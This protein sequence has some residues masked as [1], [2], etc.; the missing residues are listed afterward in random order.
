MLES[1]KK[2]EL[3]RSMKRP[4]VSVIVPAYNSEKTIETAIED[5]RNQTYQNL[6]IIVVDDGSSDHTF[7]ICEAK[8]KLDRRIKIISK[9]NG[10]VASARN[11][12][13]QASTG[14][15]IGFMDADDRVD[16]QMYELLIKAAEGNECDCV[17][18]RFITEYSD[19]FSLTFTHNNDYKTSSVEGNNACLMAISNKP[20]AISVFLWN[21]IF[22][23][24]SI[25]NLQFDTN[26]KFMEDAVFVYKA[27]EIAKRLK[28]IDVPCYHYRYSLSSLSRS[29]KTKDYLRDVEAVD[30][31][32]H[33]YETKNMKTVATELKR[34]NLFHCARS[35]ESIHLFRSDVDRELC[36]CARYYIQ[37][38]YTEVKSLPLM[39]K[40]YVIV[41]MR[42]FP[43]YKMGCV[44]K[45]KCKRMYLA[46]QG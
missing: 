18:C 7:E 36:D 16:P 43:I 13:K 42:S 25:E 45:R 6:E 26:M 21:K 2:G 35:L 33:Y 15:W 34:F 40:L 20:E 38:Y 46:I 11:I 5:L 41:A 9:K 17:A 39:R 44:M 3:Y 37:K 24:V 32:I 8:A 10:G 27:M 30:Q 14:E 19:N 28:V 31:L 23:K 1:M 22:R 29:M 4:M 12:G